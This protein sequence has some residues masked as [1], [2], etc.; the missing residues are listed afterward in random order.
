MASFEEIAELASDI[1]TALNTTLQ[2]DTLV[3][4]IENYLVEDFPDVPIKE[5]K[6]EVFNA[7][8]LSDA[9]VFAQDGDD[10]E[11]IE[12]EVALTAEALGVEE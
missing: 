8:L 7:L 12:A 3:H 11:T 9:L 5:V 1:N 10:I 6:E 2:P 4:L